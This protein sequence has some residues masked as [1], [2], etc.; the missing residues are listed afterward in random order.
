MVCDRMVHWPGDADCRITLAAKLGEPVRGGRRKSGQV[1]ACNLTHLSLS[2]HTGTHMDA[3]RHFIAEGRTLESLPLDAV[4]GPCRVIGIKHRS[5]ITIEGLLPHQL[6]RGERILFK[7]RNSTR[8]WKLAKTGTFDKQFVYIP[9][10]TARFLV[11][12]GLKTVGVDY[13]SVGGWQKDGVECHRVLLGA[14]VW[15]IEGLDLSKIQPGH[16]DLVCL[17]LKI[18]GADGA[19][20]RAI[21]RKR[22]SRCVEAL[23]PL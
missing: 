14:E 19:P 16:Y 11:N 3:P 20:C 22:S 21:L 13:L 4:I 23:R 2:A 15:I 5:A 10:D 12:R 7:T 1:S 9:A 8:S 17:P 18:L 6:K